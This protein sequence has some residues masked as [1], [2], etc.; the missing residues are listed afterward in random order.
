MNDNAANS[1]ITDVINSANNATL[2]T[3]IGSGGVNTSTYSVAGKFGGAINFSGAQGDIANA[4]SIL[5]QCTSYT[6]SFWE[7]GYQQ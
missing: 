1:T 3:A 6:L 7:K 2:E 4:N 5:T